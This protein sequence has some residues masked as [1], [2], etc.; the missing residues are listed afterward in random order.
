MKKSESLLRGWDN[1]KKMAIIT[2]F[3]NLYFYNHVGTLYQQTRGLS[4]LQVSSIWAVITGAIFLFEVPTG[5]LADKIGRKKSVVIAL[6]LQA[7]GEWLYLFANNY[8]AFLLIA[9]LAGL[10]YAFLSGANEALVYDSLPSDNRDGRMKKAMGMM[11]GAYQL[12]FCAAPLIGGLIVTQLEINFFLRAIL[13]TAIS[14]TL[15]FFISLTL[16]EP[17]AEY[18][19]TEENLLLIFRDGIKQILKSQKLKWILAVAMLTTTFSNSL[20]SLYQPYF[21]RLHIPTLW[22]GAVLSMGGLAAFLIQKNIQSIEQKLG[23]FTFL[24]LSLLPGLSYLAIVSIT[25][26]TLLIPIFVVAYASMEARNPLLASYRNA[27][28]VSE[29]R[30]TILSLMNMMTMLYVAGMSLVFGRIADYSIPTAF[31]IIGGLIIFFTLVLRVDKM[32]MK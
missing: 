26:P 17:K 22:I 8:L 32:R 27:E 11:G 12:A 24:V 15:A 3:S 28:I 4:L 21:A 20:L 30:A 18:Q 19:H 29:H 16:K 9:V 10:G 6:L 14:V 25:L 7:L 13:L 2:F 23:R 5:I 31:A 1:A